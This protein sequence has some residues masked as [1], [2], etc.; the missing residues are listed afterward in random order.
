MID[1]RVARW[2]FRLSRIAERTGWKKTVMGRATAQWAARRF[3]GGP[4]ELP[5]STLSFR[6]DGLELAFPRDCAFVYARPEFEQGTRRLLGRLLEPGMTVVDVGANVGFLTATMA[7]AVGATGHLFAVEPAPGNLEILRHNLRANEIDNVTVLPFACGAARQRQV[8]HLRR[9]STLHSLH[10]DDESS[11]M[12]DQVDVR[13]LDDLVSDRVDLVKVDTEGAEMEVLAGMDRI[14][15][16]NPGVHLVVEW[17][18]PGLRRADQAPD[19]LP[20]WLRA[21]A[22]DV[23]LIDEDTGDL[24]DIDP[25]LERLSLGELPT[26]WFCNLYAVRP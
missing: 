23:R 17:N 2:L 9:H 5:P 6:L 14:L 24:L 10:G 7:R 20:R 25:L 4:S 1:A 8:L 22:F 18:V 19:A 13:R 21:H 15:E 12:E 3:L 26:D 11:P 16:E